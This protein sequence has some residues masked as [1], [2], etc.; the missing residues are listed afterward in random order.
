MSRRG[1]IACGGQ[2]AGK[3][4]QLAC[5]ELVGVRCGF[6]E[7]RA[8]VNAGVKFANLGLGGFLRCRK[9]REG[10]DDAPAVAPVGDAIEGILRGLAID[11]DHN[12]PEADLHGELRL[13]GRLL[14]FRRRF[15]VRKVC[16]K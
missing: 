11:G 1:R 16:G 12:A 7:G 9:S 6:R 15:A 13:R 8:D 10:A 5:G 4:R 2:V 14:C 3:L